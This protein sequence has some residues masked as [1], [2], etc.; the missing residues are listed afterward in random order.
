MNTQCDDM[1]LVRQCDGCGITT[2]ADIDATD[3]HA[4]Q[5][6]MHGQTVRLVTMDECTELWKDAGPCQCPK[7][8]G[9]WK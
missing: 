5:M 7:N 9:G 4:A 8:K 1:A 3:E 6:E 2:A